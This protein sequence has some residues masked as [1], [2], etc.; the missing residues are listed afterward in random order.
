VATSSSVGS[1]TISIIVGIVEVVVGTL[2][3]RVGPIGVSTA[4]GGDGSVGVAA[5][6]AAYEPDTT[7][8][9]ASPASARRGRRRECGVRGAF[10][11]LTVRHETAVAH[12]AMPYVA[13]LSSR[14]WAATAAWTRVETLSFWR[15]W[16]T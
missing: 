5:D 15:M 1:A 8:A 2:V 4:G 9:A 11:T 13:S 7:Q 14:W 3:G 10:M 12:R 6:A 16:V